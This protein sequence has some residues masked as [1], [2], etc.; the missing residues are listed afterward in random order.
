MTLDRKAAYRLTDVQDHRG[1]SRVESRKL[2][3]DRVG[4]LATDLHWDGPTLR[5]VFVRDAGG[6]F[7]K[8]PLH[9]STV[10]GIE[11]TAGRLA[12]KTL[13]SVYLLEP[14]GPDALVEPPDLFPAILPDGTQTEELI[15]LYLSE[16]NDHLCKGLYWDKAGVAHPLT[17]RIHLGMVVDSCLLY[18]ADE[19]EE[20]YF[21]R[22]YLQADDEIQFY[23]TLYGQQD[24][25][26]PLLIHNCGTVPLTISREWY[27]QVG[28][29]APGD[30]A[31]FRLDLPLEP[32][33]P[34]SRP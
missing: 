20:R 22:Y 6:N 26:V 15:E 27:G 31:L 7:I 34:W 13:N 9:T 23:D 14:V 4:C 29:V 19:K 30:K 5:M 24:Y 32:K 21:A 16:E 25:S 1:R 17:T 8:R 2:Y 3:R 33:Q 11:E 10:L 18:A 12:V 28:T